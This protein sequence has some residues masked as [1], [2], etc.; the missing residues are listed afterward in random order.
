MCISIYTHARPRRL[1]CVLV[2][3]WSLAVLPYLVCVHADLHVPYGK[4]VM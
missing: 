3:A 2:D 1:S 4:L